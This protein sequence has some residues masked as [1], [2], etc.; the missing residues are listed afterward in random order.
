M[1]FIHCISELADFL[2]KNSSC[3]PSPRVHGR[4]V[5]AAPVPET[6]ISEGP[7][8]AVGKPG[9]ATR[10]RKPHDR[11]SAINSMPRPGVQDRFSVP[12]HASHCKAVL[13]NGAGGVVAAQALPY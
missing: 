4:R 11:I 6:P 3:G 10:T 9:M 5:S 12:M 2:A 8:A 13:E 7:G 1:D